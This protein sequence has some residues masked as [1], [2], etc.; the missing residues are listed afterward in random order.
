MSPQQ[1]AD[2]ALSIWQLQAR[3][4]IPASARAMPINDNKSADDFE[5]DLEI[6]RQCIAR[7]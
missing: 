5:R 6:I 4:G 7:R 3:L 1:E 2:A